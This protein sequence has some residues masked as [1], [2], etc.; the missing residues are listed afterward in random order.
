MVEK[1]REKQFLAQRTELGFRLRN[2]DWREVD[3][4]YAESGGIKC[5]DD[6]DAVSAARNQDLTG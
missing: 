1:V 2:G 6:L 5:A 3:R 4:R